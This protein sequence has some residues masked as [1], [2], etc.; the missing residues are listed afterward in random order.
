VSGADIRRLAFDARITGPLATPRVAAT[1]A[2]EDARLPAGRLDKLDARFD[3]T[4]TGNLADASTRI[5]LTADARADGVV[6]AN[7]GLAQALGGAVT[8]TLRGS[9][10]TAGIADIEALEVR[11]PTL[12][13]RYA[14]RL[15]SSELRG[16]A[17]VAIVDLARFRGVA[18]VPLRG[19]VN[20][21]ADLEGTPRANR[22]NAV[23]DGRATRLATGIG[24]V[25][26]LSGGQLAIA[27]GVRLTPTGDYI[28]ENLRLTGEHATLRVDGAVG[29]E[30]AALELA[31]AIPDL[32]RADERLSGR[33]NLIGRVTGGLQR[34]GATLR[35]DIA[36]AT[37]LGR[38]VPRL[39]VDA[40][41]TE[42]TGNVDATITLDGEMDR[43]P[44]RGTLHLARRPDGSLALDTLD[45]LIG[46]VAVRGAVTL[47]PSNLASGRVTVAAR[48]LDDL[49]PLLLTR[50]S[51]ALAADLSLANVNGGQNAS[52]KANGQRISA[53]RVTAD[54]LRADLALSDVYR[55]PVIAGQVAIDEASVGGERISRVRLDATGTAQA[56]DVVLTASARGFDLD[57][58]ARVIPGRPDPDRAVAVRRDPGWTPTRHRGARD[59]HDFGWR[60]RHPQPRARDRRGPDHGRGP[61]RVASRPE[62]RSPGRSRYRR[63]KSS[64]RGSGSP[65]RSTPAPTLAAPPRPRPAS[66]APA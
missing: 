21:A 29:Q 43:K 13:A 16:R 11:T 27:G 65:G 32:R 34:P 5:R 63:S 19:A 35:L 48:D 38:P 45:I 20:V 31:A 18:G 28:V 33:A 53:Y 47:D 8:L 10:T 14:G 64:P 49:S 66:T 40:R 50:L 36:N 23:V 51:G 55:R 61:R 52:L 1:L 60:R 22:Y 3:A 58:R 37:A 12:S 44:A 7:P 57:A 9:S 54:R 30:T 26:G 42:I 62:A 2:A 6:P 46:S 17:E 15:G 56:S 41:V 4:P 59:L 39:A 25:D 24:P